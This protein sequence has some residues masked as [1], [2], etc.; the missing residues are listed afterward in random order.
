MRISNWIWV[1]A[2][3]AVSSCGSSEDAS[4]KGAEPCTVGTWD[5]GDRADAEAICSQMP[6]CTICVQ[7]ESRDGTPVSWGA[8]E[9]TCTC[10]GPSVFEQDGG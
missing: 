8:L 4:K 2:S 10:P 7:R 5:I 1:V 3:L 9:G 6:A